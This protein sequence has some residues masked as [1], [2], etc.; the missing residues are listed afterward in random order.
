MD[1]PPSKA[2]KRPAARRSGRLRPWIA[3]PW[4][5]AAPLLV[6]CGGV[7]PGYGAEEG[8][9]TSRSAIYGGVVDSDSSQ[10]ASVVAIEIGAVGDESFYLCTGTLIAPNVVLTA[11][12]CVSTELT[13]TPVCDQNGNTTNGPHFGADIPVDQ[14]NVFVTPAIYQGEASSS[15]AKAIYHPSGTTE[16]NADLALVVLAQ[17]IPKASISRVR[18]TTPVIA[19]ESTR[20]VGFGA[21]NQSA[22]VYGT[23][24]RKDDLPVLAVGSAISASQTPLGNSEFELGGESTMQRRLPAARRWTRRRSAIV[25]VLS[26]GSRRLRRHRRPHLHVARRLHAGL[27]AGVRRRRRLVG[28]RGLPPPGRRRV[29]QQ[30][31]GQRREQ[32]RGEQ[33]RGQRRLVVEERRD[34]LVQRGPPRPA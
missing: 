24:Y 22:V 33:R 21:N 19:G 25:G 6:A 20:A 34:V 30:R 27:P 16:C 1:A 23:R 17:S 14:I 8:T 7:G 4:V 12:H 9:A 26:R 11:R 3:F 5:A 18:I 32:R 31:R 29:E 15:A 10:N 13:T 2:A 28:R